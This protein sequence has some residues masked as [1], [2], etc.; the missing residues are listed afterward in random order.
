M[1]TSLSS[2]SSFDDKVAADT[3]LEG[4]EMSPVSETLFFHH[5]AGLH[6]TSGHKF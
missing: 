5:F 2:R 3:G 4:F 6:Y 1:A